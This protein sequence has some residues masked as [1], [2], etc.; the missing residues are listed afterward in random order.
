MAIS[1]EDAKIGKEKIG[2][3]GLRLQCFKLICLE[4]RQAEDDKQMMTCSRE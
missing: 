1:E 2:R 4:L 3:C